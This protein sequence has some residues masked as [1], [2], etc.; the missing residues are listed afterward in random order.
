MRSERH[1]CSADSQIKR[2]QMASRLH[3]AR[4]EEQLE[5]AGATL[6]LEIAHL[7]GTHEEGL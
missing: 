6:P 5:V 4:F 3:W 2:E 1:A 7:L